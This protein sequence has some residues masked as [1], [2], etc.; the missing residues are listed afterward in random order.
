[1]TDLVEA[2]ID[3]AMQAFVEMNL[4]KATNV[5]DGDLRINAYEQKIEN[6]CA[7]LTATQSPVGGDLRHVITVLK[8]VTDLERVGDYSCNIAQAILDLHPLEPKKH[9]KALV[10]LADM[11]REMLIGSMEAYFNQNVTLAYEIAGRDEVVDTHYKNLYKTLILQSG[12]EE[13]ALNATIGLILIGRYLE[14][15]ADHATNICE[16]VIYMR[17]GKTV[18]F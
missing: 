8:V 9:N 10:L 6:M 14:R 13:E 5:I 16:R 1:M 17:T 7:E 2:S 3:V 18:K 15:I 4:D 11:V 12:D